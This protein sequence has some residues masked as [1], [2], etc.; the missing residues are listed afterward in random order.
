MDTCIYLQTGHPLGL[1][2]VTPMCTG[3]ILSQ[4]ENPSKGGDESLPGFLHS[5]VE[6]DEIAAPRAESRCH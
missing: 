3:P 6:A 2:V 4:D 5:L 1:E